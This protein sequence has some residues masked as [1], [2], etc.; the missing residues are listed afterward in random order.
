MKG[1]LHLT[2]TLFYSAL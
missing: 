2:C 1:L